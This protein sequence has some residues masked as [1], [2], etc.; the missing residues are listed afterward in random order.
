MEVWPNGPAVWIGNQPV[1]QP[2]PS[3]VQKNADGSLDQTKG[4]HQF[5][6]AREW[7]ANFVFHHPQESRDERPGVAYANPENH[8]DY[9]DSPVFRPGQPSHPH[10]FGNHIGP[11]TQQGKQNCQNQ[12]DHHPPELL[13]GLVHRLHDHG[14]HLAAW[15][16]VEHQ[17]FALI[18]RFSGG[19]AGQCNWFSRCVHGWNL[20]LDR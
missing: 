5:G 4:C 16:R 2:D 20:P 19:C 7:A 3:E 12:E 13:A 18:M 6:C 14:I 17:V 15:P 1:P 10:T 9:E 8:I 11:G